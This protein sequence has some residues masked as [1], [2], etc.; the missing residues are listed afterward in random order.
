MGDDTMMP[1]SANVRAVPRSGIRD[2]VDRVIG[3][4]DVISLCVGEPSRTAAPHVVEAAA[5]ARIPLCLCG[6]GAAQPALAEAYA[7]LGVRAFSL[8]AR[9]LLEVKE[10]LMGVTL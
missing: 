9:E 3:I 5:E 7:R 4:D 1:I 2:V 6:E 8:P 10:Y